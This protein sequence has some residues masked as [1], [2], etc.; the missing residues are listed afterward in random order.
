MFIAATLKAFLY[1]SAELLFPRPIAVEL[2]TSRGAI[3]AWLFMFEFLCQDP[4]IWH[5]DV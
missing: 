4:G 2:L 5:Y 1:T 3:L